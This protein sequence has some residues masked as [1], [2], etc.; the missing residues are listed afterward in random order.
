MLDREMAVA[1]LSDLQISK[2]TW[3]TQ[4]FKNRFVPILLYLRENDEDLAKMYLWDSTISSFVSDFSNWAYENHLVGMT[5]K[6]RLNIWWCRDKVNNT[7]LWLVQDRLPS[8]E[9]EL[10]Y[11][12]I[13]CWDLETMSPWSQ[14]QEAK[15]KLSLYIESL[16]ERYFNTKNKVSEDGNTIILPEYSWIVVGR[17]ADALSYDTH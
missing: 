12:K 7:L 4:D 1:L 8:L 6:S 16:V 17:V 13:A 9:D 3:F 10:K 11:I 5:T 2:T 15:K 14:L